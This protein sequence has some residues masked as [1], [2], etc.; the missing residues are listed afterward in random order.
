MMGFNIPW[1]IKV[2]LG[3]QYFWRYIV[4]T[5]VGGGLFWLAILLF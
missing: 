3:I 4:V 2:F 1:Y 5:I